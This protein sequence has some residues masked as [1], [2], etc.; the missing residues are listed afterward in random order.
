MSTVKVTV[1]LTTYT[2]QIV[3]QFLVFFVMFSLYIAKLIW[4]LMNMIYLLEETERKCF[5]TRKL[6]I[7]NIKL[8]TTLCLV[9][10]C[11][12][13]CKFYTFVRY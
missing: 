12:R 6:K 8:W 13:T 11:F 3:F 2:F 9:T 10:V 7:M 1:V 5:R 4:T